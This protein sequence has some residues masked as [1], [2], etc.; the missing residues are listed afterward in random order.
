MPRLPVHSASGAP[1]A[2]SAGFQPPPVPI[3]AE[4]ST[5]L[6]VNRT[7]PGV[8]LFRQFRLRHAVL[9]DP[10]VYGAYRIFRGG[11]WADEERGCLATNRRR[12]HP[13][14]AIED[15]GFGVVRS[16]T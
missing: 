6:S 10:A 5:M 12:R 2:P 16:L 8:P 4:A 15:L 3:L 14:F 13:T 11:G 9:Y 1:K 7:A